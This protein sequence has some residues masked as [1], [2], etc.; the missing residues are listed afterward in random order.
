MSLINIK[1]L[2]LD[3]NTA[4]DENNCKVRRPKCWRLAKFS[5]LNCQN[6]NFSKQNKSQK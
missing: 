3:Q 1:S 5:H 6:A 4:S 2:K